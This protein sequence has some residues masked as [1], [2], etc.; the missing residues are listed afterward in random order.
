MAKVKAI[1]QDNVFQ[2]DA[3]QDNTWGLSPFQKNAFQG[4]TILPIFQGSIFQLS[5]VFQQ[6][7]SYN[8]FDTVSIINLF[9]IINE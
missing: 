7:H 5:G 8:V 6:N 3:F 1:F 4:T 9:K 2:N